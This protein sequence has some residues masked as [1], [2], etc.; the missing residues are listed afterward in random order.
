M[1]GIAPRGE[2]RSIL[3]VDEDDELVLTIGGLLRRAGY[4]VTEAHSGQAAVEVARNEVPELVLLGVALP[5][6]SGFEIYR[7]LRD[8]LGSALRVIFMSRG[9]GGPND[10][11]A[12][13]LLGAD[14]YLTKP[15]FPDVLLARVRRLADPTESRSVEPPGLTRRELEILSL[16]VEGRREPEIARDLYISPRT[17]ASRAPSSLPRRRGSNSESTSTARTTPRRT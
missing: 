1:H 13:L 5:D 11:V 4:S 8:A 2:A 14:D 7:E 16:L 6:G 3:I 10:E 9:E 12:A 17:V 15:F